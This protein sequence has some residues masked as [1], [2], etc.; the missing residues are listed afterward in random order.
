MTLDLI[1]LCVRMDP[2]LINQIYNSDDFDLTLLA[3]YT[4]VKSFE[5]Q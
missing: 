2:N 4:Q 3:I 5:V 1:N